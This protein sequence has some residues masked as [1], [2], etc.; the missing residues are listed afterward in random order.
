VRHHEAILRRD[1][2]EELTLD[3]LAA[4][5]GLHPLVVETFVE[6]GLIEPVGRSGTQRVF[7]PAAVSRVRTI[8]RLRGEI[9][10]NLPG[11][12]VILDLLDRLRALQGE[13]DR[14]RR[15]GSWISTA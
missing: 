15:K 13:N 6:F 11:I 10:V 14:L 9:G 12:A 8:G 4:S 3:R 1:E 7:D 2:R 5:A